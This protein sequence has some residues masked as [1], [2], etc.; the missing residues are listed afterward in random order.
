MSEREKKGKKPNKQVSFPLPVIL[1][2]VGVSATHCVV[3]VALG[4]GERRR[5]GITASQLGPSVP[6]RSLW[7]YSGTAPLEVFTS[8]CDLL[9][10]VP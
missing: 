5:E 2:P 7:L 4:R 10:W 6:V 9:N 3:S 1:A 8:M